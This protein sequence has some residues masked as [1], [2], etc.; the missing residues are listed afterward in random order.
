M[1]EMTCAFHPDRPTLLRCNRCDRPICTECA[2]QTPTGYRCKACV[3]ELQL[4]FERVSWGRVL[5][6]GL[7]AGILSA[8]GAWLGLFL[9]F[10][11]LFLAPAWGHLVGEAV[12]R[13]RPGPGWRARRWARAAILVGGAWP[14]VVIG[15]PQGLALVLAGAGLQGWLS[16]VLR[17]V[18]MVVYVVLVERMASRRIFGIEL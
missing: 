8:V 15:V 3:R 4:R 14:L 16:F 9:G 7:T 5:G 10:W 13:L 12:L 17:V 1:T 6:I 11:V 18:W 2:V